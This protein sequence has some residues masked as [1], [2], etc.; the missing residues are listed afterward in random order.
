LYILEAIGKF[1][2]ID[3]EAYST[4]F[5]SFYDEVSKRFIDEYAL[6]YLDM[7]PLFA[8]YPYT[9]LLE[10]NCYAVLSLDLLNS[11]HLIDISEMIDFIWSCYNPKSGGF[12]GQPYSPTLPQEFRVPTA[13]NTYYAV[14]IL[15]LLMDSWDDN[16][17]EKDST[18]TFLNSLQSTNSFK[19]HFGGF[20]NDLEDNLYTSRITEPNILSSYYCIKSL[21]LF[22]LISTVRIPDFHLFL[23]HAYNDQFHYFEMRYG[24]IINNSNLVA[25]SMGL[26]L[27]E[28]TGFSNISR[29]NVVEFILTNRNEFGVWNVATMSGYHELTPIYLIAR[30]LYNVG[31]LQ[32]LPLNDLTMIENCLLQLYRGYDGGFTLLSED[33]SKNHEKYCKFIFFIQ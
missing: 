26:E 10:I 33:Y 14:K 2:N 15:D 22:N 1:D 31:E 11:L 5:L 20:Y 4:Y 21:E 3:I 30:S 27:A 28:I 24:W 23:S 32:P 29:E 6:R 19:G 18:I 8:Y 9:S 12:L 7:D 13:D 17:P 16:L 25:T